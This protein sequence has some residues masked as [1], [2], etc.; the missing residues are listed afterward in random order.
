MAPQE[1]E[2]FSTELLL[3][4][5]NL[6]LLVFIILEA[7]GLAFVITAILGYSKTGTLNIYMLI[8]GIIAL[9]F[10]GIAYV[11]FARTRAELKRRNDEAAS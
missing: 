3:R 10:S 2:S 7:A 6:F 11:L 9:S 8:P 1:I 5:R 4:R